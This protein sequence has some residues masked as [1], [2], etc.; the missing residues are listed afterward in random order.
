MPGTPAGPPGESNPSIPARG[1][2]SAWD[3]PYRFEIQSRPGL[4]QLLRPQDHIHNFPHGAPASS[5]LRD[6]IDT[7]PD[8]RHGISRRCA[9]SNRVKDGSIQFVVANVT[10]F[11]V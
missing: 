5:R 6:I 8:F 1:P 10:K 7:A 11:L 2:E 9:Q 3:T 4:N